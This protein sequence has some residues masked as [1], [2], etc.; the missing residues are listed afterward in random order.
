M[1]GGQ[2]AE[3]ARRTTLEIAGETA[4]ITAES[5]I[6]RRRSLE[7]WASAVRSCACRTTSQPSTPLAAITTA[8]AGA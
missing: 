4:E 3:G 5:M 2:H 8:S 6:E 1:H 7:A